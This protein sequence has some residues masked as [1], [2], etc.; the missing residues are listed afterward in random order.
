LVSGS[1]YQSGKVDALW[2]PLPDRVVVR[3]NNAGCARSPSFVADAL[4]PLRG[5][6]L[7]TVSP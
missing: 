2:V 3:A 7:V 6:P 4:S 1:P 5:I